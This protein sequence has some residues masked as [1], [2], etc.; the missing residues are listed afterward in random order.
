MVGDEGKG[1]RRRI[2]GRERHAKG[3]RIWQWEIDIFG[4]KRKGA[5]DDGRD[6]M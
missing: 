2:W 3:Q 4:T 1:G 6:P 5:R